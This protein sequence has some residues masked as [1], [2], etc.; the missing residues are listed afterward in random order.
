MKKIYL[1]LVI[2]AYLAVPSIVRAQNRTYVGKVGEVSGVF[3]KRADAA[4]KSLTGENV[5]TLP[6][7]GN[8]QLVLKIN[9]SKHERNS[10]LFFGEVNNVKESKF[11]LK[12]QGSVAEG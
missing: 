2:I 7:I 4:T 3:K 5:V 6:R 8:Q 12:I 9:A 1:L 10:E 11:Y